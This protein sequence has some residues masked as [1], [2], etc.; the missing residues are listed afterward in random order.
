MAIV[1]LVFFPH[2]LTPD[3]AAYWFLMQIGMLLGFATSFPVNRWLLRR[4]LKEAM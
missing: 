3:H 1:Q 2:G 4:G